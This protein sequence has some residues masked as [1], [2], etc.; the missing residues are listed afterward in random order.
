MRALFR[1]SLPIALGLFAVA[2]VR[3]KSSTQTAGVHPDR[4]TEGHTAPI[5]DPPP[6]RVTMHVSI[7]AEAI[8]SELEHRLPLEGGGDVDLVAGQKLSYTWK[9]DP[10]QLRFDRGRLQVSTVASV[11]AHFLGERALKIHLDVAGE[12]V[13]TPD[14]RAELQS[15]EVKVSAGGS[16]E[17]VNHAVEEKLREQLVQTLEGFHLDVRPL[18]TELYARIA[19]PIPLPIGDPPSGCAELKVATIEAGPT[20]LAGGLEKDLGVV[21]LPSVTLPCSRTSTIPPP[22]PLL[23]N[24]AS[25]PSGPF[26]VVVPIAA[27]Y[28]ELSRAMDKAIGGRLYFSKEHPGLYMYRPEVFASDETV[29]IRMMIGGLVKLGSIDT[30]LDGEIFFSGHPRLQDNQITVPDLDLTAGTV[31]ALLALKLALDRDSIREQARSALRLDVSERI[32]AVKNKLSTELTFS[33]GL[34]CVRAELL[35]SEI[36][37]IYPHQ[38]FLRI[39]VTVNGQGAIYL[40]CKR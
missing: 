31:D 26:T 28:R 18:L 16:F 6:S 25:I 13:I 40:P 37:G 10:F 35:R 33:D 3:C 4:P 36:T 39:Y 7:F 23:A 20:V 24:V 32:A 12:P 15:T 29:V 11:L 2:V 8:A 5:P 9:R 19:Q 30:S 14:Y 21:V 38:S 34:G 22:L 27:E 17:R 1:A